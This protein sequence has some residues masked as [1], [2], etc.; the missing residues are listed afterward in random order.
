MC[1]GKTIRKDVKAASPGNFLWIPKEP[2][3][4]DS[5]LGAEKLTGR[6]RFDFYSILEI[7]SYGS[8]SKH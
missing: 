3:A 2:V 8:N 7:S 5:M 4:S 6:D 1:G